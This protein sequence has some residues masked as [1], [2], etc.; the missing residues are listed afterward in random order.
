MTTSYAP[1]EPLPALSADLRPLAVEAL[2]RILTKESEL[3]ELWEESGAEEY[4]CANQI[5][6]SRAKAAE[7]S[8][9]HRRSGTSPSVNYRAW[10][11]GREF[12]VML[13]LLFSNPGPGNRCR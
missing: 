6:C 9:H 10:S 13:S 7:S 2:D 8:W 12:S 1:K 11:H 5:A 3:L 4:P